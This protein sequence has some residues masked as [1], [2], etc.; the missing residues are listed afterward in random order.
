MPPEHPPDLT[1]AATL[2]REVPTDCFIAPHFK[3]LEEMHSNPII[4]TSSPR[5]AAFLQHLY[6][7]FTIKM[8]RGNVDTRL[9][10]LENGHFHGMILAVAGLKRL[11]KSYQQYEL[12]P[13][14]TFVPRLVKARLP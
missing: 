9:Q 3:T 7:H 8:L 5:R 6:P 10:K 12:L 11:G 14:D 4:A 1:P 13:P 2:P